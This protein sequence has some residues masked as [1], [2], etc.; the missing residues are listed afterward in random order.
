DEVGAGVGGG[1]E[2]RPGRLAEHDPAL[3]ALR[4]LVPEGVGDGPAQR[5]LGLVVAVGGLEGPVG[6]RGRVVVAPDV[7]GGHGEVAQPPLG[8]GPAEGRGAVPRAV[9]ADDDPSHGVRVPGEGPEG[10][11]RR[12]RAGDPMCGPAAPAGRTSRV[13]ISTRSRQPPRR[14]PM[15]TLT[16]RDLFD[17]P[18]FFPD[19]FRRLWD[20]EPGTGWLRVEEFLDD[21]GTLVV[22]AELP[23]IDPDEDVDLRVVNDVLHIDA[24]REERS[25]TKTKEAYRSEFRYGS[26]SRSVPLPEGANVD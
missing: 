15:A 10:Q 6:R 18:D 8:D 20:Y 19:V 14:T 5:A 11:G 4:R 16:R 17:L 12:P 3:D 21:D 25:E 23:D 2:E 7:H 24:R 26:F 9:D 22:R 1:V 13:W